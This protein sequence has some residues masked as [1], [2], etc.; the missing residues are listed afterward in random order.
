MLNKLWGVTYFMETGPTSDASQYV[1]ILNGQGW[2]SV[3]SSTVIAL[4]VVSCLV[5]G[6]FV[7]L[8]KGAFDYIVDGRS[9]VRPL[10]ITVAGVAVFWPELTTWLNPQ[11]VSF[12]VAVD[13]AW[14]DTVFVRLGVDSPVLGNIATPEVTLGS[15]VWLA[16]LGLGVE[17]TSHFEGVPFLE[18][19]VEYRFSDV[20]SAGISGF[21]GQ[22]NTMRELRE[23]PGG[24]GAQ[25]YVR[26]R[27]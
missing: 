16:S 4:N 6:G 17:V 1:S 18:G 8:A 10:G 25:G 2:P 3:T 15:T 27:L 21:Y 14:Q 23:Y 19:S 11:C 20:L 7:S 26:A 9:T 24:P 5:S 12:Q 22:G 13:A